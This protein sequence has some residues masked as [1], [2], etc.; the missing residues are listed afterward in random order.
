MTPLNLLLSVAL[1]PTSVSAAVS[2]LGKLFIII[3]L[4]VRY[5]DK[6]IAPSFL[7]Q[8]PRGLRSYTPRNKFEILSK[9]R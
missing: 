8:A 7:L 2:G 3:L 9:L 6:Q 5:Y 1:F 4:D